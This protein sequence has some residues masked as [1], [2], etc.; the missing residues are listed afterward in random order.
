MLQTDPSIMRSHSAPTSTSTSLALLALLPLSAAC[1]GDDAP[2]DTDGGTSANATTASGSGDPSSGPG[3]TGQSGTAATGATEGPETTAATST[4]AEGSESSEGESGSS[5]TGG[6]RACA[7][8]FDVE[9]STYL[10]GGGWEHTR[11]LFVDG[12]GNI[13]AAG[14]TASADFPTTAGAYDTTFNTGGSQIGGHGPSDAWVAMFSPDGQ[15]VWSTYLGGPNYDRAYAI[16]VGGDGHV[17]VSGRS[18]PGFPT[19]PG[20]FQPEY[21]GVGTTNDFYGV[22]NGFIAKLAP[23]GSEV[24]WSSQF[25]VNSLVRDF[26]IDDQGNVYPVLSFD[27]NVSG[28]QEPAWFSGA[29]DDAYQPSRSGGVENGLAKVSSDGTAVMWATWLGG[30]GDESGIGSVRV[31]AQGRPYTS[32][33]TNSGDIPT[34]TGNGAAGGL[35]V[36]VARL[37]TEGAELEMGTYIGGS[38]DEGFETHGLGVAGGEVV[39]AGFTTSSDFPATPGAFQTAFGGGPSDAFAMRLDEAGSVL[40]ATYIGGS[41][42]EGP[43]GLNINAAGEVAFAGETDSVDFPVTASAHQPALGG[44]VDAFVVVLDSDFSS[45][46]YASFLGGGSHENGRAAFITDDCE[47][48]VAGASNGPGWPTTNAYQVDFAGGG[49]NWGNGDNILAKLV[50]AP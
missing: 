27:P 19:T 8:A 34:T 22:Q 7:D 26:D 16:E 17:Y 10:G 15:L 48:F 32:F 2:A 3:T 39:V 6:A 40:S 43:D 35:D 37:S 4:T 49:Q 28:A 24:V 21:L 5:G 1:G 30:S 14:G 18:G 36:Y 46:R 45:P 11:D 20:A 50:A 12:A 31:D 33:Y 44:D 9:F 47:V 23:D 29:F 41:G 42:F 25:G 38:G 13:Y